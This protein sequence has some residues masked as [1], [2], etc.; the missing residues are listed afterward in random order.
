MTFRSIS[1]KHVKNRRLATVKPGK[2]SLEDD[3]DEEEEE[4]DDEEN[5]HKRTKLQVEKRGG[6]EYIQGTDQTARSIY[7]EDIDSLSESAY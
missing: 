7:D 3:D 5:P 4:D 2:R 6:R 1:D